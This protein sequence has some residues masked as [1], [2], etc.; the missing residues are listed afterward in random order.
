MGKASPN[1]L[2]GRLGFGYFAGSRYGRQYV[3]P[4]G[5]LQQFVFTR[6]GSFESRIVKIT[7]IFLTHLG[8]H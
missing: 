6:L 7:E 4:P 8:V 1:D 2:A 5:E 3:C